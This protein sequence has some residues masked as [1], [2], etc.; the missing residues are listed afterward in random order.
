MMTIEDIKRELESAPIYLENE[1]DLFLFDT[2]IGM[3][4]ETISENED[5]IHEILDAL[6]ESF[7][8]N[9]Y[10]KS[11]EKSMTRE[12]RLKEIAASELIRK[13]DEFLH[14]ASEVSFSSDSFFAD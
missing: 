12:E 13:P 5:D 3:D 1:R 7:H 11:K 4:I 14:Y 2:V 6:I 10:F 8:G 9:I